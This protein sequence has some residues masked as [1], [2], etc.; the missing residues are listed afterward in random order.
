MSRK[1]RLPAVSP[2]PWVPFQSTGDAG[3][4]DGARDEAGER[5]RVATHV[6]TYS[7]TSLYLKRAERTSMRASKGSSGARP[8]SGQ[9][10]C[11]LALGAWEARRGF[12]TEA[13]LATCSLPPDPKTARARSCS[14]GE[15]AVLPPSGRGRGGTLGPPQHAT[16]VPTVTHHLRGYPR[17]LAGPR[18]ATPHCALTPATCP[19]HTTALTQRALTPTHRRHVP[20]G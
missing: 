18:G 1:G 19:L 15:P 6:L 10:G 7:L 2:G 8:T 14:A 5:A 17:P 9:K 11:A 20:Q 3:S 13:S 16:A 4:S 12:R